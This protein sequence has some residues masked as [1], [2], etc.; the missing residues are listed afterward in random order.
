MQRRHYGL[1]LTRRSFRI[2]GKRFDWKTFL[3]VA[4]ARHHRLKFFRLK[5]SLL[6]FIKILFVYI[7]R[8]M[9][10]VCLLLLAGATS[11]TFISIDGHGRFLAGGF[12][13]YILR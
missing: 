7:F 2:D 10:S 5:I 11:S 3:K 9:Y 13:H 8:K 12:V 4:R 6:L 1:L